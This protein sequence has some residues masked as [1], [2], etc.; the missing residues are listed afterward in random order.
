[1]E[2]VRVLGDHAHH[3]VQRLERDVPQVVAADPH[4]PSSGS[5]SRAASAVIVVLPA[6]DGPTSAVS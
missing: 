6:P 3:V 4:A 2:Q 5:Y 1:M